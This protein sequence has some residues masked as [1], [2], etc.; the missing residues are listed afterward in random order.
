MVDLV[1]AIILPMLKTGRKINGT[2]LMTVHVQR[3]QQVESSRMQ[4][5]TYFTEEEEPWI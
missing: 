1:E 3:H 4:L 5:I 2:L